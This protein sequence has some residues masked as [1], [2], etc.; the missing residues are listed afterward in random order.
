MPEISRKIIVS[1]SK[2]PDQEA[3]L[4]HWMFDEGSAVKEG[5]VV[6][7]AMVDKVSL[8]IVAPASGYLHRLVEENQTFQSDD[9]VAE[10]GD[11]EPA[12][13]GKKSPSAPFI[14]VAPAIRHYAQTQGIDLARVQAAHPGQRITRALLDQYLETK[15]N[16]PNY[17]EQAKR[18]VL[19]EKLSNPGAIPFTLHRYLMVSTA[20]LQ[21]NFSM[22][23]FLAYALD[24]AVKSHPRLNARWENGQVET[25][26]DLHLGLAVNTPQGLMAPAVVP[27]VRNLT[28]WT[29]A[30]QEIKQ[31][32]TQERWSQLQGGEQTFSLSNLGAWEIEF[33]TPVLHPPS[34]A[35]LGVGKATPQEDGLR[36]PVSLTVDHRWIDGVEGAEFLITLSKICQSG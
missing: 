13:P 4:T 35:I 1:F 29:E 17:R 36:V 33:F 25:Q 21:E 34:V 19:T 28:G 23:A 5:D 24:K 8:E 15:P 12:A 30:I 3:V 18:Q 16:S 22:T 32:V 31:L 27:A 20:I 2:D 26:D 9:S 6:A 14:P 7:E 10:I 11:R